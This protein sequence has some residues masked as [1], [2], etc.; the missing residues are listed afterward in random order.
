MHA[1]LFK[2]VYP[3]F[4]TQHSLLKLKNADE[5]RIDAAITVKVVALVRRNLWEPGR[6]G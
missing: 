6:H 1:L 2:K 5:Y 3:L 4:L